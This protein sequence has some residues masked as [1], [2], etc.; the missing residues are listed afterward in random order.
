MSVLTQKRLY[1]CVVALLLASSSAFA[2]HPSPR[3]YARMSYDTK[4]SMVVLFGGRAAAD[5]ATSVAHASNETWLFGGATWAQRFPRTT[6]PARSVHA[7]TNDDDTGRVFMF[8]GRQ[9]PTDPDTDATFLSDL[10]VW[11]NDNWTRVDEQS[12]ERPSPRQ[13]PGLSYD[14]D[15]DVI[16][17]YGGQLYGG[18]D[19]KSIVSTYD[20]WEFA[21]GVWTRVG[22]DT[23]KVAKPILAYERVSKQLYMMGVTDTTAATPV[24]YR[25]DAATHAWTQLTPAKLPACGAE[26]AFHAQKDGRLIFFG[27]IC[28]TGTSAQEEVYEYDGTTWTKL[29]TNTAFRGIGQAITWDPK[30]D[31]AVLFG[32]SIIYEQNLL[33]YT[34]LYENRKWRGIPETNRHPDARS[35]MVLDRDPLGNGLL[36]YGGLSE[37][38]ASGG[39][40][41]D[42][43]IYRNG[44]WATAPDAA[45]A[46]QGCDNPL[47]AFDSD[48]NRLL[49]FCGGTNELWEFDG[50][51]WKDFSDDPRPDDRRFAA[52]VYDKR[53]K[54]TVLFGGFFGQNYR[55]DTW[56]WDGAKWTEVDIDNDDRPPHRGTMA[57]WYD[58]LAQKTIV[59]GGVGRGSINE[60]VKRF[61]D[62]WSFDGARWTN[63]N[64]AQT[65]GIRFRPLTAIH[66]VTGKL[67]MFG[68]LRAEQL[69]E[70]S[71]DQYFGDDLWEWD[72][73][74]LKWT[75]LAQP[76]YRPTARQNGGLGYDP[77]TGEL[78]LFG[79]YG[80]GF[81]YSDTWT[82]N[83]TE[84][85]PRLEL[86]TPRRR[87]VH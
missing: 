71:V 53:L 79:G 45:N 62:M 23:P 66:P 86:I 81:Y 58:P 37:N 33:A 46:P 75:Q 50:T 8:G 24:M 38:G 55:N 40:L 65:P 3:S 72:G 21:N 4:N 31:R 13:Y 11:E 5:K 22:T 84:W 7:M 35:L 80:N 68:G 14:E 69:D 29:T 67:T 1:L 57:M 78:V 26:G 48:R 73:A 20:T 9:E 61:S 76:D 83:G 70:D 32:G 41:S 64:I 82:W 27:G 36:M 18:E 87:A 2:S 47:S 52:M 60:K 39:Y 30:D 63:M 51:T 54:K 34:S 44:S 10:W 25:Y 28:R 16:V 42:F 15:R 59:Y 19:G 12:A 43:W 6:P 17:L 74:S 49:V 56:T 77:A 85:T